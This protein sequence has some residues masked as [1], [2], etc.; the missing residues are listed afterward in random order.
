MKRDDV[1]F[2]DGPTVT[3]HQVYPDAL[4]PMRAD[5]A[6]LGT[7][8][9]MAYRHCEPLRMAS[10]FGWYVFPP[11]DIC[12]RWNGADV[13]HE[14]DGQWE[15][16]SQARLPGFDDYWNAHAPEELH[17]LA[18]PFLTH[19]PMKGMVQIWSGLL[20]SSRDGFSVLV[21]PLANVRASHL[22]TCFEGLVESDRFGPFP[23]FINIQLTATDVVIDL[24]RHAPLFQ[25][26]PLSR[27]TYGEDAHRS[28]DYEG[29]AGLDADHPAMDAEDWAGYRKTVRV[30]A[31]DAP[32]EGGSYTVAT[33]RR[34]RH[35]R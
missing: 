30:V 34:G 32:P 14:V 24:P 3:F 28:A 6:A 17:D 2:D 31:A 13:F 33:R 22:Y 7:M 29:L 20:C 21:R 16:L 26:Q 15:V 23:L 5:K 35:E 9:V 1:A 10:A 4:P 11:L 18:P 25:V 19:L 12:L 27:Q 8:P